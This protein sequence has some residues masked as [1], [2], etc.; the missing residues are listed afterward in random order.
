MGEFFPLIIW[1]I[2]GAVLLMQFALERRRT[3]LFRTAAAALGLETSGR[4]PALRLWGVFHGV[5]VEVEHDVEERYKRSPLITFVARA[6]LSEAAL[7]SDVVGEPPSF[8]SAFSESADAGW[9]ERRGQGRFGMKDM[10]QE[11]RSLIVAAREF[12]R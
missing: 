10:D 11:L 2:P 8:D 7:A 9:F 6:R 1:V 3:L 12:R 5:T 4:S